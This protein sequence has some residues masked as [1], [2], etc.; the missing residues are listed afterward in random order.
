MYSK[1]METSK[2]SSSASDLRAVSRRSAAGASTQQATGGPAPPVVDQAGVGAYATG[3]QVEFINNDNNF[4][5]FK[6]QKSA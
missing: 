4:Y 1:F 2:L 5:S 6:T 3:I